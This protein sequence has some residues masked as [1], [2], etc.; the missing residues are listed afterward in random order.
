MQISEYDTR[1]DPTGIHTFI[2]EF[3]PTLKG[4][5]RDARETRHHVGRLS[6]EVQ[7]TIATQSPRRN[8]T[9]FSTRRNDTSFPEML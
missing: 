9:S 6:G 8:L 3:V 7:R 1:L 4:A 5:H 2:P